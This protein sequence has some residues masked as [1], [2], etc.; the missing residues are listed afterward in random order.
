MKNLFL[1]AICGSI[2]LFGCGTENTPTSGTGDSVPE[3]HDSLAEATEIPS[4]DSA[5]TS[6]EDSA[7]PFTHPPETATQEEVA[8]CEALLER[9]YAEARRR[10]ILKQERFSCEVSLDASGNADKIKL[11]SKVEGENGTFEEL[12]LQ[13]IVLTD[14]LP[15]YQSQLA[16]LDREVVPLKGMGEIKGLEGVGDTAIFWQSDQMAWWDTHSDTYLYVLDDGSRYGIGLSGKYDRYSQ[17][18]KKGF[19]EIYELFKSVVNQK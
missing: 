19:I 5:G 15:A 3:A 12:N 13:R 7:K 11:Y 14:S 17:F 8:F 16:H 2:V 1:A 6:P 18:G 9:L 4:T 10:D